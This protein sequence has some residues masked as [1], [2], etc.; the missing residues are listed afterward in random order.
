MPKEALR[1]TEWHSCVVHEFRSKL[2]SLA[3]R[4]PLKVEQGVWE[5]HC[6]FCSFEEKQPFFCCP[7]IGGAPSEIQIPPQRSAPTTPSATQYQKWAGPRVAIG[8]GVGKAQGAR[9]GGGGGTIPRGA[10]SAEN[11]RLEAEIISAGKWQVV[12][13]KRQRRRGRTEYLIIGEVTKPIPPFGRPS[14]P[15]EP[16]HPLNPAHLEGVEARSLAVPSPPV[17]E[18]RRQRAIRVGRCAAD[19]QEWRTDC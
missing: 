9:R 8:A 4:S 12:G 16:I 5:C 15:S 3:S 14:S 10:S 2:L 19:A 17:K 11:C 6:P 1:C 18:Q 13:G 7:N